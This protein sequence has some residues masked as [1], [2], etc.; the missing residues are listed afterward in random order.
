MARPPLWFESFSAQDFSAV[1]RS[2]PKDKPWMIREVRMV[3]VL[4]QWISCCGNEAL[5]TYL[6]KL[7]IVTAS[8]IWHSWNTRESVFFAKVQNSTDHN[9]SR[10]IK[11]LIVLNHYL[12]LLVKLFQIHR[13][14]TN[15]QVNL[16][17]ESIVADE[18]EQRR[19]QQSSWTRRGLL[20]GSMVTKHSE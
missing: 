14:I 12:I 6:G 8:E 19:C 13:S 9:W 2:A 10:L 17:S 7:T 18:T 20:W 4:W 11:L 5:R 3:L 1:A 16:T 15:H